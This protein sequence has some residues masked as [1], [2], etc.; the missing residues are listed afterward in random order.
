MWTAAHENGFSYALWV[1][2][3]FRVKHSGFRS[4]IRSLGKNQKDWEFYFSQFPMC[5]MLLG[6][7][8]LVFFAIFG[9]KISRPFQKWAQGGPK[10]PNYPKSFYRSTRHTMK[11]IRI[12][13]NILGMSRTQSAQHNVQKCAAVHIFGS[14]HH[15]ST[16][17]SLKNLASHFQT[18]SSMPGPIQCF[19]TDDK[20]EWVST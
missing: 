9:I 15:M 18:F 20:I 13:Y 7:S 10:I 1:W 4:S 19:I 3:N 6:D 5:F 17:M 12:E 11:M 8:E 2:C 14:A 16:I